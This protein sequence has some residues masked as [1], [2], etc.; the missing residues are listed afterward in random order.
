MILRFAIL[1]HVIFLF[2]TV[3][4]MDH[5]LDRIERKLEQLK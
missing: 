1:V 5:T 2:V 3:N 4:H